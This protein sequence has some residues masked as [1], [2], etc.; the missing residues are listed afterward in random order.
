M[1]NDLTLKKQHQ[2]EIARRYREEH[3][4]EVLARYREINKQA[5]EKKDARKNAKPK[6]PQ[7]PFSGLF[8]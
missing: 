3:R 4:E 8:D 1:A 2:A 7:T 5:K 6:F